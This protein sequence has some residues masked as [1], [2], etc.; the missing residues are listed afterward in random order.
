MNNQDVSLDSVDAVKVVYTGS[1]DH[2]NIAYL[3]EIIDQINIRYENAKHIYLYIESLG[4]NIDAGIIAYRGLRASA[5]PITTINLSN[6]VPAG[7]YLFCAGKCREAAFQTA[8]F[9]I[10]P[11]SW[12]SSEDK[13]TITPSKAINYTKLL[14]TYIE[15]SKSIYQDCSNISSDQLD[16]TFYS[17]A[18]CTIIDTTE[19]KKDHIIDGIAKKMI[20]TPVSYYVYSTDY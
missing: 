5:S 9:I 1:V 12:A 14:N 13:E 15:E 7:N 19:A 18:N 11:V 20:T 8:H 16:N 2:A 10:H 3:L 17:K 6:I 4:G